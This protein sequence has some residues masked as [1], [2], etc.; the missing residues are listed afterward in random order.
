MNASN[1][2]SCPCRQGT[3]IK[4]NGRCACWGLYDTY[5]FDCSCNVPYTMKN[6]SCICM[7]ELNPSLYYFDIISRICYICPI[8]C[9]CNQTGC[10]DCAPD[11]LRFTYA[12]GSYSY[13]P[14]LQIAF[15]ING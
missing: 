8:G 2:S 9:N 12:N 14:C 5:K 7:S 10:Y 3:F 13:C 11:S 15:V 1:Y 6:G 4:G